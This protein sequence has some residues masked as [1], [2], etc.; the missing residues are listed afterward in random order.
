MEAQKKSSIAIDAPKIGM[1]EGKR[2]VDKCQEQVHFHCPISR[3]DGL[4]QMT[5][6]LQK[7]GTLEVV[8]FHEKH[9]HEFA[10]SPM[11]YML[12]SKRK[13]APAQKAIANDAKKSEISIKQA[14]DLLSMQVGG[15]ENL[16]FLDFDYKN[17]VHRERKKALK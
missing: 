8:Y 2:G 1:K 7:D 5:C 3:V 15:H 11:N 12:R 16:G 10:L 9:K 17:L 14:I 13:I 4:A 6:Q